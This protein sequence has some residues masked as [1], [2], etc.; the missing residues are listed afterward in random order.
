MVGGARSS[1]SDDEFRSD[2]RNALKKYLKVPSEDEPFLELASCRRFPISAAILAS[3]TLTRGLTQRLDELDEQRGTQGNRLFY[4]S[5]P[6]SF[7]G[8]IV[9]NLG[10]SGLAKPKFPGKSWTRVVIEKPFG[11]DLDSAR[12]LNR[13]VM[14][15]FHEDQVYRIDHYL[16]KET[17]QNLLVFRFA[18]GVFEPVWNRRYID[19]VQI[20]VAEDLAP[21]GSRAVTTRRPVWCVT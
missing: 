7:F 14:S 21:E 19:H 6:P 12:E 4:M 20:A 5:T 9:K 13:L 16:G 2:L 8:P 3:A 11:H 18:N 10:E 17:V 15:V 1:F